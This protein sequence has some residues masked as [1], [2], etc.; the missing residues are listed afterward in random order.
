MA[1]WLIDKLG[2]LARLAFTPSTFG[3]LLSRTH[4]GVG[5]IISYSGVCDG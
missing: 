3:L 5:G 2:D 1:A 4:L